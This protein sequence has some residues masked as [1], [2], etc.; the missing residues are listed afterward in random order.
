M[1]TLFW[2]PKNGE[3]GDREYSSRVAG[4]G[5]SNVPTP[6][7]LIGI[8]RVPMNRIEG[9]NP[10]S[11]TPAKQCDPNH[12]IMVMPKQITNLK[13]VRLENMKNESHVV[14]KLRLNYL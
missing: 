13:G 5:R 14:K 3:R 9:M 10:D 7:T 12:C 1:E 11:I 2:L 8:T 4:G 6:A